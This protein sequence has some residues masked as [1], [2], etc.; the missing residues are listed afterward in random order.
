MRKQPQQAC[1]NCN[2]MGTARGLGTSWKICKHE[3]F[4]D[5]FADGRSLDLDEEAAPDWCPQT[6]A[7]SVKIVPTPDKRIKNPTPQPIPDLVKEEEKEV[8]EIPFAFI[9][10]FRS[11]S[12]KW[13]D[14]VGMGKLSEET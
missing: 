1:V 13:G 6:K 11:V 5:M 14:L 10:D 9:T 7:I 8:E 3:K 4:K 12:P 2:F